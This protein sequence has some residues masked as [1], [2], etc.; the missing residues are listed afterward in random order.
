MSCNSGCM[1]YCFCYLYPNTTY[2]YQ[3][4]EEESNLRYH[5]MTF[6]HYK[7]CKPGSINVIFFYPIWNVINSNFQNRDDS[8]GSNKSDYENI[9]LKFLSELSFEMFSRR[10]LGPWPSQWLPFVS[11]SCPIRI[12]FFFCLPLLCQ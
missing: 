2:F 7:F 11:P 6:C 10:S 3:K 4:S 8:I 1:I 9:V 12:V 5:C